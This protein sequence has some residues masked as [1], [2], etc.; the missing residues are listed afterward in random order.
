[1]SEI[2]AKSLNTV[3][4]TSSMTIAQSTQQTKAT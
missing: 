4:R 1:M 2:D 3:E